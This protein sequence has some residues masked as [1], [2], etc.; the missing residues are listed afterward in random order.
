[1]T[2]RGPVHFAFPYR[3]AADGATARADSEEHVRDLIEAILFTRRGERVN[4]P[5]FGAGVAELIFA[6][7]APEMAAAAQHMVQSALQQWLSGVIEIRGVDTF[8]RDSLLSITVRY[9]A[10]DEGVERSVN[11]TRAV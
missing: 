10:L 4:R 8:S 6:E 1:M 2:A 11:V 9:R 5:D 7:N 3:V